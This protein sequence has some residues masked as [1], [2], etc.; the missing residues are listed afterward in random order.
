M[1]LYLGSGTCA[2]CSFLIWHITPSVCSDLIY[3]RDSF[4][5]LGISL[6]EIDQSR[7]ELEAQ[8]VGVELDIIYGE[9]RDVAHTLKPY[10]FTFLKYRDIVGQNYSLQFLNRLEK[11]VSLWAAP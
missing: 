5:L 8:A 1:P 4:G 11:F 2:T 6:I 3:D 7:L 9:D 10:D